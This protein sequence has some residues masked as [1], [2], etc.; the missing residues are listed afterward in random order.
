MEAIIGAR[1]V[2]LEG[3]SRGKA[4]IGVIGGG[5]AHASDSN[6]GKAKVRF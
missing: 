6:G 3:L 4:G 1:S 5:V 2:W